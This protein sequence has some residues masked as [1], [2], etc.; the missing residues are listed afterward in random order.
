MWPSQRISWNT[1][2]RLGH[3]E[4]HW[5]GHRSRLRRGSGL[6]TDWVQY[7]ACARRIVQAKAELVQS[8]PEHKIDYL[9]ARIPH[10]ALAHASLRARATTPHFAAH[11]A[12]DLALHVNLADW[13]VL[14]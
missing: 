7:L 1:R 9:T 13:S 3:C 4:A 10:H 5:P 11:F 6:G 14:L 8:A 2:R 12:P